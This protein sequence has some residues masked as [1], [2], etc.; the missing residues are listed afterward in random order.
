MIPDSLRALTEGPWAHQFV[1]V[2]FVPS[3]TRPGKTEKIP[4]FWRTGQ[5]ADA[6]DPATRIDY[7]TAF[8]AGEGNVGFVLTPQDPFFV[9]DIDN[10]LLP[11]GEWSPLAREVCSLLP[12]CAV[13]V[14]HS[15]TGL[16]IWGTSPE[17]PHKVKD[18]FGVGLELYHSKRFIALSP[19][20]KLTVGNVMTDGTAGLKAII[21]KYF[22]EPEA[23]APALWT[24]RPCD[25]WRGPVGDDE[26]I[27]RALNSQSAAAAFGS[28]ASFAQLWNRDV[29]VL[30][31][32]YPDPARDYDES[33]ADRALAQHLAFWTGKDCERIKRLMLLSKL[34]RDKWDR[35]DYLTRTILSAVAQQRDVLKDKPPEPLVPTAQVSGPVPITGDTYL[36]P[37]AQALI[38]QGCVY[39]AED[40]VI[41]TPTGQFLDQGRFNAM[42]GGYAYVIDRAAGKLAKTPWDAFHNS[43]DIKWPHVEKGGFDPRRPSGEIYLEDGKRVVNTYR[44]VKVPA[45]RGNPGPFLDHMRKVLPKE[46]D[47]DILLAYMAACVQ[48]PGV[49][50]Q[51]APLLQGVE[52][53]GKTLFSR[54]LIEA[55]GREYCHTPK[56]QEITSKFNDWLDRKILIAVEDV[57]TDGPETLEALK[58]MI[59]SEWLEIEAKGQRKTSKYVCANFLFNSNHRDAIQK[60][61][62]DRRF[63]VFFTDQQTYADILTSGMGGD[64]F[65]RL[66]AWLK[67]EGYAIVTD[68]LRSYA[69][70]DHLNPATQCHR[71]P[72]T[73]TTEVAIAESLG[74]IEQELIDAIEGDRQGFRGGWISG[75]FLT[76]MLRELGALKSF[77]PN[78]RR[79]LCARLGYIPHPALPNGRAHNA[80]QPDGARS[81][82]YV[83]ANSPDMTCDAA[84]AV[85]RYTEAQAVGEVRAA[86]AFAKAAAQA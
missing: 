42:L 59:T 57:Y 3:V 58:P 50:F 79:D 24:D 32:A 43:R 34:K 16:H 84:E 33:S 66:Y 39:I 25:D 31:V 47:R 20:P 21:A 37:E 35:E 36:N 80:V 38:F 72:N 4:T 73:S 65:P 29:E 15:G 61:K 30:R 49:K 83:K 40:H 74:S 56:A 64:Y 60:T 62:N 5:P 6:H 85:R 67:S 41:W 71:A 81:I 23:V 8:Q 7:Y 27:R 10:C 45:K 78:R 22:D 82:L 54:V 28:R 75:H 11:N 69:I 14:S 68:Y 26:L 63:A 9:L 46:G 51:W 52:G 55:I 2:K 44:P 19:W 12:G 48:Y 17:L 86:L 13:E 1:T 18:R 77:N 70:P 76:N 53:N